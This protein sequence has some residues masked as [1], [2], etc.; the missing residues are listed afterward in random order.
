MRILTDCEDWVR[1]RRTCPRPDADFE[2]FTDP[3]DRVRRTDIRRDA[4]S[5]L[6]DVDAP[7][8]A[9]TASRFDC[10]LY[11]FLGTPT[12]SVENEP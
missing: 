4:R 12:V 8:R 5:V 3:F 10:A 11:K 1:R 2:E 9:P 7:K 6:W